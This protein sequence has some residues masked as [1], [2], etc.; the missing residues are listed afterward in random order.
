MKTLFR[1]MEKFVRA[2]VL[3]RGEPSEIMES[4]KVAAHLLCPLPFPEPTSITDRIKKQHPGLKFTYYQFSLM[5]WKKDQAL[6]GGGK[7]LNFQ[8]L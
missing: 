3:N 6:P 7:I 5:D 4:T 2:F 1:T 8:I